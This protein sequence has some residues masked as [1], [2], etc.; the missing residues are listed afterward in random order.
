M[1]IF[2]IEFDAVSTSIYPQ[3]GI[4]HPATEEVKPVA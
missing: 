1:L 2:L 4:I 3:D